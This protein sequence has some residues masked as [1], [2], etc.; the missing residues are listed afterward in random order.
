VTGSQVRAPAALALWAAAIALPALGAEPSIG[1]GDRPALTVRIEPARPWLQG[2]VIQAV[3]LISPDPFT[4]LTLDLPPVEGASA[5]TLVPPKS[6]PFQNYGGAGFIFETVRALFPAASGP[7]RIPPVTLVGRTDQGRGET[8]GFSL[9]SAPEVIEVRPPPEGLA[10]D[11]W[12]VAAR[13]EI[14]QRWSMPLDR[15]RVGDSFRREI[16]VRAEG[17]TGE[18]LAP[19]EHDPPT[20]L[21][22]L[23]GALTRSTEI[24]PTG[25]IGHLGQTFELR[26][27]EDRPINL[28]PIRLAW[29]DSGAAVPRVA[30]LKAARIE[31]LPRD[32]EALVSRLMA[33]A[34]MAR[35]AQLHK[36]LALLAAAVLSGL[37]LAIWL[38]RVSRR[39]ALTDRRLRRAIRGAETP[40]AAEK[41]IRA[42]ARERYP[43]LRPVSLAVLADRF[44]GTPGRLLLALEAAAFGDAPLPAPPAA[45]VRATITA[46]RRT[47]RR[48]QSLAAWLLGPKAMLPKL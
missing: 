26:V 5:V 10:A 41:L 21:A 2:Q 36:V 24:T 7:L 15:L 16:L 25:A 31:P 45:I 14:S 23:P 8:A 32:R 39:E 17:V 13:V 19:L 46:A 48:N 40:L 47:R 37:G 42:W 18:H 6:R 9:A 43:D 38:R 4:E 12:L 35:A 34:E 11:G 22:V 1:V 20:G 27:E 29:W 33:A 28:A 30:V 3:R 44:G